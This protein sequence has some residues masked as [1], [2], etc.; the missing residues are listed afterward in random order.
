M[1]HR[2]PNSPCRI[3]LG[4]LCTLPIGV[5]GLNAQKSQVL[6]PGDPRIN[7]S[8]IAEHAATHRFI[9][10]GP[11]GEHEVGRLSRVVERLRHTANEPAILVSAQFRSPNRS[12][13]DIVYADA[14]T[15]ALQARYLTAPRGMIVLF[16]GGGAIHVS[17]SDRSGARITADTTISEEWFAG[18]TDLL[19]ASLDVSQ[20]VSFSLP[21]IDGSA[22]TLAESFRL[23]SVTYAGE[24][25][26][27]VQDVWSG[28]T[29]RFDALRSDGTRIT[30][31]IS[32][33]SPFLIRQDFADAN[34]RRFLRWELTEYRDGR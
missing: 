28:M 13:L 15:L 33:Q 32:G 11:D 31:W 24:E 6:R 21:E 8:R 7:A 30:Y 19:L 20:G 3:L 14:S 18:F 26:V 16:Q 29:R 5:T 2:I 9:Q 4:L 27:D 23:S 12:G 34:R 25:T 1:K 22:S 10:Y 17:Y